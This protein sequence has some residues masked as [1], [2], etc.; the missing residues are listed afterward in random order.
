MIKN[1]K[2]NSSGS[3]IVALNLT[4]DKAPT[5]PRDNASEDLPIVITIVVTIPK[6]TKFLEKSNLLEIVEK[7]LYKITAL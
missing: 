3:L 4:I 7:I 6:I 1:K 2:T 5:R